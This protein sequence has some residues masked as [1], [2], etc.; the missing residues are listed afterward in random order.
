MSELDQEPASEISL[1]E[2]RREVLN[3]LIDD[4]QRWT[5]V[6]RTLWRASIIVGGF[7]VGAAAFFASIESFISNWKAIHPQ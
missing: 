2:K 6:G 7:L 4:Y 3:G 5:A 1:T